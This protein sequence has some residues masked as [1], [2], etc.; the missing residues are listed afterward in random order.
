MEGQRSEDLSAENPL[1]QAHDPAHSE[2][3]VGRGEETR[4]L[5]C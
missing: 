1:E 4:S 5:L 2:V 3:G